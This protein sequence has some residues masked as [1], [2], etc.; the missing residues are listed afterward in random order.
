MKK[1]L[2]I[3]NGLTPN[4]HICS[5]N[6]LKNFV[7]Y[8]SDTHI[9]EIVVLTSDVYHLTHKHNNN[10]EYST[11]SVKLKQLIQSRYGTNLSK[12]EFIS[13]PK[14]YLHI[15]N[16]YKRVFYRIFKFMELNTLDYDHIVISRP[17]VIVT[18][19]I[20]FDEYDNTFRIIPG[21]LERDDCFHN[22]DWDYIWVGGVNPFKI[23]LYM[24]MKMVFD[25]EFSDIN[26]NIIFKDIEYINNEQLLV[27][28]SKLG[29]IDSKKIPI[30]THNVINYLIH[31]GYEFRINSNSDNIY[32]EIIR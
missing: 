17:D 23:W 20:K 13:I 21:I 22:R 14:E 30:Y 10:L 2:I 15:G 6:L 29:L 7:D 24:H 12:V 25:Y 9:C 18:K 8:N 4:K 5:E 28:I 19:P 31:K 32:S 26:L 16:W 27:L 3:I 11:D 1:A